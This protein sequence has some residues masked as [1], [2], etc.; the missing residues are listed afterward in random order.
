MRFMTGSRA[1][2]K[3]F[4]WED[5]LHVHAQS[6]SGGTEAAEGPVDLLDGGIW[7]HQLSLAAREQKPWSSFP[8]R[9]LT[10]PCL[11]AAAALEGEEVGVVAVAAQAEV[12]PP[13]RVPLVS[14]QDELRLRQLHDPRPQLVAFIV[15]VRY[16]RRPG[17]A[18]QEAQGVDKH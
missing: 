4:N 9:A 11:A 17:T 5:R 8:Q 14:V 2:I 15:H 16:L 18:Q 3:C 7:E 13:D 10:L 6:C 12:G 1:L